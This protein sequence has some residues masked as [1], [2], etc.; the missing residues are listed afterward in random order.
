[1][2]S[3]TIV[4]AGRAG[5][6]LALALIE[7]GFTLDTLIAGESGVRSDLA[8]RLPS[9]VGISRLSDPQAIKSDLLFI[10]VPDDSI[11]SAASALASR[12]EPG[13]IAF[14]LSGSVSSEILSPLSDRGAE[15][16]S[17]HPLVSIADP[18]SG[19]K[20]LKLGYLCLEG[21]ETAKKIGREIADKIGAG[22][23]EIASDKKPLYH[24]AAVLAAG[25]LIALLDAANEAMASAIGSNAQKFLLPL[26]KSVVTN[27]ENSA[28]EEALTGPIARGD[29]DTVGRHLEALKSTV[30]GNLADVY[31][32]LAERS[33]EI[34]RRR[35]CSAS[36]MSEIME[37]LNIAKRQSA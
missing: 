4:G 27:L 37:K 15:I 32:S 16:G 11:E 14:H 5:G 10:A 25:H 35:G 22:W 28:P 6:A 36:K 29:A 20:T 21:S 8:E 24:A 7:A 9:N 30:S 13:I 26:V 33:V 19:M 12:I 18:I 23:F 1:M 34:A 2:K 31:I 17:L 3:F